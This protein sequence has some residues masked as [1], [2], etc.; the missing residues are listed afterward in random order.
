[1]IGR[2]LGHYRIV[3]QIGAGGMGVVYRAHD[4]ELRRDVA[5]KILPPGVVSD[6]LSRSQ[7]R[8]EA[9]AVAK[10]NH[11][12]IAM[13]FD[14]GHEQ[15][16]D[17]LVTEYIP[18]VTLDEKLHG[19]GPLAEKVT[20]DLSVQ[21]MCGLEIAHREGIVHRDLKPGN[22]RLRSDGTL[23]I[24]D[25][26]LAKVIGPIEASGSTVTLGYSKPFKGTMPYMSPEQVRSEPADQRSDIWA[27]GAVLYE[28]A[29]G[30]RAFP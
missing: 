21:L 23:K 22:L 30:K 9:L 16:V 3:E 12:N 18:G 11:P 15:G 8:S 26:G 17:F 28:M 24:L 10:L 5:V 13:A 20:L 14:F 27:A 4:E 7:L 1:M 25:F 2:L 6:E 19:S 29:T